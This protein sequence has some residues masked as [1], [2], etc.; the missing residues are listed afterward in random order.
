MRWRGALKKRYPFAGNSERI[1]QALGFDAGERGR[2]PPSCQHKGEKNDHAATAEHR[3]AYSELP[4]LLS[5]T[6]STKQTHGVPHA[7]SHLRPSPPSV[8][9][10]H[11]LNRPEGGSRT[12]TAARTFTDPGV[13]RCVPLCHCRRTTRGVSDREERGG[14][15]GPHPSGREESYAI[16]V[17]VGCAP[18]PRGVR[19]GLGTPRNLRRSCLPRLQPFDGRAGNAAVDLNHLQPRG[20]DRAARVYRFGIIC[21]MMTARRSRARPR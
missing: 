16:S 14:R 4:R 1:R 17:R 15:M 20:V 3:G 13:L 8:P 6:S 12:I 11:R 2:Q 9:E 7:L 5:D 19:L 21:S 18:R 10:F